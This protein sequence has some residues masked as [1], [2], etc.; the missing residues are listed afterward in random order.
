L[1]SN[2]HLDIGIARMNGTLTYE[3]VLGNLDRNAS[4]DLTLR[5]GSQMT[6]PATPDQLNTFGASWLVPAGESLFDDTAENSVVEEEAEEPLTLFDL[7]PEDRA[8]ARQ[9]CENANVSDPLALDNC[10]YDVAATGDPIFVESAKTYEESHKDNPASDVEIVAAVPS[11]SLEIGQ[12]YAVADAPGTFHYFQL[13]QFPTENESRA[14]LD[15]C[16]DL[17]G[18]GLV[19]LG[20]IMTE[21]AALEQGLTATNEP[22]V[23]TAVEVVEETEDPSEPVEEPE[24]SVEPTEEVG[25]TAEPTE[26]GSDNPI[27]GLCNAPLVMPLFVGI[28]FLA[29]NRRRKR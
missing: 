3:G 10:T 26:S 9:T 8:E 7:N 12:Q 18:Q 11:Q 20:D 25:V 28:G 13:T 4:N 27:S 5:D 22:C 16:P 17:Q 19:N 15:L 29:V 1:H 23:A 6:P 21:A 2:S 14:T 24:V